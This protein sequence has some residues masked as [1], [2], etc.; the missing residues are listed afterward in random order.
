[1]TL[2]PTGWFLLAGIA[3]IV[4]ILF[5][6]VACSEPGWKAGAEITSNPTPP[7]AGPAIPATF[8]APPTPTSAATVARTCPN[9]LAMY[10]HLEAQ[11]LPYAQIVILIADVLEMPPTDA[12]NF[13][14]HCAST[15]MEERSRP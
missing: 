2:T 7:S 5:A 6:N 10:K 13:L 4:V 1:M 14:L 11:G 15:Y 9:A 3:V 8:P 12:N